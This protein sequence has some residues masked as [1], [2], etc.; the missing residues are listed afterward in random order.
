[1]M[2]EAKE[3]LQV[4]DYIESS[5]LQLEK[6]QQSALVYAAAGFCA[7]VAVVMVLKGLIKYK[8]RQAS[9]DAEAGALLLGENDEDD[10]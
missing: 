2:Y 6:S 5:D 4:P 1:M 10:D 9:E 8:S 7:M 3:E